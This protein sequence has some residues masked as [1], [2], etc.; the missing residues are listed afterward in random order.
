MADG[1]SFSNQAYQDPNSGQIAQARQ[2]E[3]VTHPELIFNYPGDPPTEEVQSLRK[4]T[5]IITRGIRERLANLRPG[6]KIVVCVGE[7][8]ENGH[9]VALQTNV[10]HELTESG[11]NVALALEWPPNNIDLH[12]DEIFKPETTDKEG[13]KAMLAAPWN[14]ALRDRLSADTT[15]IRTGNARISRALL[16]QYLDNHDIPTFCTDAP[17]DWDLYLKNERSRQ[18]LLTS[19]PK[20]A[21]AIEQASEVLR[22][23]GLTPQTEGPIDSL[24]QMGMLTRNMYMFNRTEEIFEDNPEIQVLFIEAGRAHVTGNHALI[25]ERSW[26]EHSLNAIFSKRSGHI[27][28]GAPLY[29]SEQDKLD[30]T[31]VQALRDPHTLHLEYT[32]ATGFSSIRDP[33]ADDREVAM[34]QRLAPHFSYI[35]E[36]LEG[37]TPKEL[38]EARSEDLRL[39]LKDLR[40]RNGFLRGSAAPIQ[41]HGTTAEITLSDPAPC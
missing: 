7:L 35:D 8:H 40:D 27:F 11:I 23:F 22:E 28:I 6:Q 26:Y 33:E 30:N 16:H 5:D 34:I 37:R 12:S 31:P 32:D 1:D 10:I 15:P 38:L 3:P 19:D 24:G 29:K 17:R 13:I 9:H 20:V 41:G 25:P 2:L 36:T 14:E 39:T 4:N 21:K 18:D